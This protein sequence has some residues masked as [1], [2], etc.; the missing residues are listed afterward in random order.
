MLRSVFLNK[1]GLGY[2]K[3]GR[4]NLQSISSL[5]TRLAAG[6]GYCPHTML[7]AV[8]QT[9]LIGKESPTSGADGQAAETTR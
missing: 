3:R 4:H 8:I 2:K 9:F 7:T 6:F 5:K 1:R